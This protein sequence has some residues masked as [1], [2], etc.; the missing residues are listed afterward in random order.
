MKANNVERLWDYD[1]VEQGQTGTDTLVTLTAENIEEY[2]AAS[3]ND[4]SLYRK[5]GEDAASDNLLIA[6]PTMVVTYAPLLRENIAEASGFVAL[7]RSA[8]ARRQTPFAKCEIRW[9]APVSEEDVITGSRRVLEKYERRGSRFVTFRVEASNQ[10]GLKVGEY[11]TLA[12]LI[13]R[14][15]SDLL[16]DNRTR[17]PLRIRIATMVISSIRNTQI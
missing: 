8:T 4:N 15:V 16:R 6:M 5:A 2:A 7:E 13:T 12:S 14:K 11:D 10:D 17:L 1:A 3:Q 9:F